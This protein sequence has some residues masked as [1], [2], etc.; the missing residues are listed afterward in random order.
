MTK[1]K[2]PPDAPESVAEPALTLA[3]SP[4][5]AVA[6][7]QFVLEALPLPSALEDVAERLRDLRDQAERYLDGLKSLRD[8]LTRQELETILAL[9]RGDV[10][11]HAKSD[12]LCTGMHDDGVADGNLTACSARSGCGLPG[13][14][15]KRP[16]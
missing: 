12:G 14:K 5:E 11:V 6:L 16:A 2:T 7:E 15:Y 13:C 4:Q 10:R 8:S 1:R 3:L 9:R